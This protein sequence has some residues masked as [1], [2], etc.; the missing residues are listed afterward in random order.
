MK[1]L[2]LLV[3]LA[4]CSEKEPKK[5]V[6][7]QSGPYICDI[8]VDHHTLLDCVNMSDMSEVKKIYNATNIIEIEVGK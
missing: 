3:L 6:M 4:G 1:I 8:W 2:I 5:E 7:Y